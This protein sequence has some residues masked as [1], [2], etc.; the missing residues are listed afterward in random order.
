MAFAAAHIT[1]TTRQNHHKKR[2]KHPTQDQALQQGEI[3]HL[4]GF[5]GSREYF[6]CDATAR[7]ESDEWHKSMVVWLEMRRRVEEGLTMAAAG[8]EGEV[9]FASHEHSGLRRGGGGLRDEENPSARPLRRAEV[10]KSI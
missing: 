6:T 5:P 2:R 9:A 8:E 7:C 1:Q 4:V 10:R 3:I